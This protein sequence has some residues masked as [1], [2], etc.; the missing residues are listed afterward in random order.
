M[1]VNDCGRRKTKPHALLRKPK[2]QIGVFTSARELFI[3]A[4]AGQQEFSSD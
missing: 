2:A 3:V 4:A 1:L